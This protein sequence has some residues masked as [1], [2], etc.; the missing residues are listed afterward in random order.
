MTTD[1]YAEIEDLQGQIAELT[2]Q[3]GK[4]IKQAPGGHGYTAEVVTSNIYKMLGVNGYSNS[5]NGD[6][7]QVLDRLAEGDDDD[8]DYNPDDYDDSEDDY[9]AYSDYTPAPVIER[10]STYVM[11]DEARKATITSLS[12]F[13]NSKIKA[14]MAVRA[15]AANISLFDAKAAVEK[16]MDE[17]SSADTSITDK[18]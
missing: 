15:A 12:E 8:Y 10:E 2:E 6:V 17:L 9:P 14:I 11:S 4:L 1:F 16:L 13:P 5:Y 7:Q 18:E 3:L